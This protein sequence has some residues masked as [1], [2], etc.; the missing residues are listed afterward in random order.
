MNFLNR[1]TSIVPFLMTRRELISICGEL[2]TA[3]NWNQSFATVHL[4]SNGMNY[5]VSVA[6]ATDYQ[7]ELRTR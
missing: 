3:R 4:T 5:N 1:Y 2:S 7:T 6:D